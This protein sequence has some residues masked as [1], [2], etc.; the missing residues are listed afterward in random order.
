MPSTRGA[1]V[2]PPTPGRILI[3]KPSSLGDIVHALP[4][5]SALRQSYPKAHIAWMVASSFRSLL[6]GHPLLDEV[7]PFDRARYGRMWRD[8]GAGLAF[9]RFVREVRSRRF[10]LILD[11]QGLM[12]SGLLS[13]FSGA[14][15]RIG[16]SDAREGAWCCYTHRVNPGAR[17]VH[18][19]EKNLRVLAALGLPAHVPQFPLH[20]GAADRQVAHRLLAQAGLEPGR[21]FIAVMPGTRWSSKLWPLEHLAGLIDALHA[22]QEARCVLFGAPDE[23][24]LAETVRGACRS[25]PLDLVGRTNLP[26]LTAL[27]SQA[28]LAISN[29]SGPMHIAAALGTP[30]VALFGPTNPA[31]TGPYSRAARLARHSVPCAPCLRRVC[32]LKHHECMRGLTVEQVLAQVRETLRGERARAAAGASAIP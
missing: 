22:E 8:P 27:L 15:R 19:V 26:E 14:R 23:T 6:D 25:L 9:W 30:L 20:V 28:R 18:A 2:A 29:D 21:E 11:L 16:F 13:L 12:R 1:S 4:V 10:D 31:R 17:G 24:G 7:I 3:I 32:P 5:L